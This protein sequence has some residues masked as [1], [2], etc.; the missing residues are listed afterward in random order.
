[1]AKLTLAKK[2]ILGFGLITLFMITTAV[3]GI[4]SI[5]NAGDNFSTYQHLAS[6]YDLS[7]RMQ[8]DMLM[9]RMNVKDFILKG[10]EES[11][12]RY[13]EY[14]SSLDTL[15]EQAKNNI[16][17]P[18]SALKI[19]KSINNIQTYRDYFSRIVEL[20][21]KYTALFDGILAKQGPVLHQTMSSVM[22]ESYNLGNTELT[23]L[24]G[25]ALEQLLLVRFHVVMFLSA[26]TQANVD[27]VKKE[28]AT[29]KTIIS[30][31][32]VAT[33]SP[34]I[35]QTAAKVLQIFSEYDT[36]FDQLVQVIFTR[37][38]IIDNTLEVLGPQFASD[39]EAVKASLQ[40]EQNILG[41]EVARKNSQAL[42]LIIVISVAAIVIAVLAAL[43]IIRSVLAQL[44]RD[45]AI[46]ADITRQVAQ[47]D[48]DISFENSGMRGVYADM[49]NM[50]SRLCNVVTEVSTAS[51]NVAAGAEELSSSSVS[52]SQGATEQA[53][54]VEEVSSSME[55]MTSGI[56]QNAENAN[57]TESMALKTAKDA[58]EGGE[59]VN[60]TVEAM[61]QIAEKITI[62]EEI[63]RQTN[64]L[65]LNAAIE[66]ARAGEHGKGFAVV[67]AEVRKLA[68]RS[69]TAAGEISELSSTSVSIAE[70]AGRMLAQ[71]VP[72][73]TRT[74]D[75]V[76]EITAASNEQS[77]GASQITKA[78]HQFDQVVQQNAAAAEEMS[79]TS[80]ELSSQAQQ[81]IQIMQFFKINNYHGHTQNHNPQKV[82]KVVKK[83]SPQ[84]P[85][86]TQRRFEIDTHPLDTDFE[87]F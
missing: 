67:A 16:T 28:L 45:P 44:G 51:E 72:D 71:I 81:L 9:V 25:S 77:A 32:N 31:L 29:F 87:Q 14:L 17:A 75:L 78:L 42:T 61:K 53:A 66:A 62:I 79:S 18:E 2:L 41:P 22:Q 84:R 3:V 15:L 11:F 27:S 76:Q 40:H 5:Q 26:N 20:Q 69:G 68:E 55:E 23:Y 49:H 74:A 13:K 19:E 82:V 57:V 73:I 85:I 21:R 4:F 64:L 48:L 70:K 38:D 65:A 59:A 47:G 86:P 34:I 50:V 54:S 12:K 83:T 33:T 56:K 6:T 39:L 8:A 52:L 46:I 36:A 24:A 60:A 10:K 43:I 35:K 30:Q 1:M 63:A 58:K 37:N 7:S 80:E